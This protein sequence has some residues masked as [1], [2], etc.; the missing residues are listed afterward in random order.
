[1][2]KSLIKLQTSL[3]KEPWG[4]SLVAFLR[5]TPILTKLLLPLMKSNASAR[6]SPIFSSLTNHCPS[7]IASNLSLTCRRKFKAGSFWTSPLLPVPAQE[8]RLP[9]LAL[10]M[11]RQCVLAA[12]LHDAS[13]WGAEALLTGLQAV[14]WPCPQPIP[15]PCPQAAPSP[16]PRPPAAQAEPPRASPPAATCARRHLTA[17]CCDL[18]MQ[19]PNHL[20]GTSF[21]QLHS[22][23]LGAALFK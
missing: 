5:L 1:M 23:K 13:G 22:L 15:Q 21:L 17:S 4:R 6:P 20:E 12:L 19:K 9:P 10:W 2:P 18:R 3:S 16:V 14:P 11:S 8:T 7:G